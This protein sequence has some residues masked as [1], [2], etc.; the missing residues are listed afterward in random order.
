MWF[1]K[2]EE[3]R[4]MTRVQGILHKYNK[5]YL[6]TESNQKSYYHPRDDYWVVVFRNIKV[7][8]CFG[9]TVCSEDF[10]YFDTSPAGS[11]SIHVCYAGG[12][13]AKA[14]YEGLFSPALEAFCEKLEFELSEKQKDYDKIIREREQERL[15]Y[16]RRMT[17]EEVPKIVDFTNKNFGV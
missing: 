5:V 8:S 10:E 2:S 1:K 4:F 7:E 15:K 16:E 12:F 9:I 11:T 17:E 3:P 13:W 6:G 14:E